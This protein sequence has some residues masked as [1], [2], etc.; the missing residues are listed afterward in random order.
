MN[1]SKL[2]RAE[3]KTY[4]ISHEHCRRAI[5]GM[6]SSRRISFLAAFIYLSFAAPA[7]VQAQTAPYLETGSTVFTPAPALAQ[8][9]TAPY[10]DTNGW[11][12][13]TPSLD[14]RIVY[15]SSSM[16]NDANDGLSIST[17]VQSIGKGVS[18]LRSGY[19]DWLLLKKGDIWTDQS[20][21]RAPGGNFGYGGR[22][23]TEPMVISSYGSGARP[24]IKI[25]NDKQGFFFIGGAAPGGGNYIAIVGLEL[26]S[27]QR[28]PGNPSFVGR[29]NLRNSAGIFQYN[30]FNWQLIE[31]CKFSFFG[32]NLTYSGLTAGSNLSLRRNIIVDAYN[33][34][35]MGHSQGIFAEKITGL[36]LEENLFDHNGWNATVLGGRRTIFNRNAYLQY[37]TTGVVARGNIVA[38]S[39]SEGVQFRAGGTVTNNLFI[40]NSAGFDVGHNESNP[41]ITFAEVDKQCHRRV[42]TT[43]TL[44]RGRAAL[45]LTS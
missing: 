22:S 12:V 45:D 25:A 7:L 33:L 42:L 8:A 13:F 29:I 32:N 44:L 35:T 26:Y 23:A 41:T 31:D 14:T 18:L 40:R 5:C 39:S 21:E 1:F 3:T 28:D 24:L 43:S 9:Q 11:T 2:T 17:P 37:N 36:L 20:F 30:S 34:D 16:G 19:P 10:L 27:Y 38:R 4:K 6:P 15:V